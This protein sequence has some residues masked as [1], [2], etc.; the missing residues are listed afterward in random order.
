MDG[1]VNLGE[2]VNSDTERLLFGISMVFGEA[3]TQASYIP[4]EGGFL[5]HSHFQGSFRHE[6]KP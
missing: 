6:L 2:S 3:Q 5:G 1:L 4:K